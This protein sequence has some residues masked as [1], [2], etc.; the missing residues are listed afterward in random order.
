MAHLIETQRLFLRPWKSDDAEA[1][2]ELCHRDGLCDFTSGTYRDMTLEKALAFIDRERIRYQESKVGRFAVFLKS[3]ELIGVSG[4][5][6][7]SDEYK[8]SFEINYRF[9]KAYWG[10][11]YGT[12]VAASILMYAKTALQ[13]KEIFAVVDPANSR[14]QRVLEKVGMQF[15]AER[16]HKGMIG[17]VWK[18]S[19]T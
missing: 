7:M 5:F 17:Q 10:Q 3:G 4:L 2:V 1:F 14:S 18:T 8:G 15:H 11:G 12:E 9:P 13:I 6:E 19:L 16:T